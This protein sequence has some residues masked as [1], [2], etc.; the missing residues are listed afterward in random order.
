MR[1]LYHRNSEFLYKNLKD[2]SFDID[3]SENFR[4]NIIMRRI[5]SFHLWINLEMTTTFAVIIFHN[6]QIISDDFYSHVNSIIL[7]NWRNRI[8]ISERI[9][10]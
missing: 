4:C 1:H 3:L 2:Q 9:L 6:D 5:I 7:E 8:H 10:C